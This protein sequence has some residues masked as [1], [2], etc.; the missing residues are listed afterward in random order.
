MSARRLARVAL[1]TERDSNAV[2]RNLLRDLD[3]QIVILGRRGELD[4]TGARQLDRVLRLQSEAWAKITSLLDENREAARV[5]AN[6]TATEAEKHLLD[7]LP[8]DKKTRQRLVAGPA[9]SRSIN[10]EVARRIS[11]SRDVARRLL[12]KNLNREKSGKE[13]AATVKGQLSPRTK[14]G[15]SYVAKRLVRTEVAFAYHAAQIQRA[16]NTPWVTGLRWKLSPDH[17]HTDVCNLYARKDYNV[18]NVPDIPHPNCMC[19]L[20]PILMSKEEFLSALGSGLFDRVLGR[21]L[22]HVSGTAELP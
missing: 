4:R 16:A 1:S 22:P 8:I 21:G 18:D 17:R 9:T 3:R 13:L 15:V 20:E 11:S 14:G 7:L 12:I 5:A 6:R 10:A 2:M 19:T